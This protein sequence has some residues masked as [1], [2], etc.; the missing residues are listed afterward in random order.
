MGKTRF[1][2]TIKQIPYPQQAVYDMLS[3]LDNIAKVMDRIPKDKIKDMEF[4]RDHVSMS[5]DPGGGYQTGGMRPRGTQVH[6][7]SDRAVACA[8][9]CVDSDA[10]CHRH[11][12]QN[13]GDCRGRPQSL[14][15]G[16]GAE[17]PPGG[18]RADCR[19]T[20]EDTI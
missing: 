2:S 6:Q 9:L 20:G 5:V 3:N 14:Y 7:V 13:E 1:E 18:R 15:Q 12:K 4:D 16:D 19:G 10:S 8:L 17:T 11:Y